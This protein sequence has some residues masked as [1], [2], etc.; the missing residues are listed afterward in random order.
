MRSLSKAVLSSV[1]L[2]GL[3]LLGPRPVCGAEADEATAR[4]VSAPAAPNAHAPSLTYRQKWALLVG[5]NAYPNL[6]LQYQLHYAVDDVQALKKVLVNDYGFPESNITVLTDTQ[7]TLSAIRQALARYA[8][9]QVDQNDQLLI[10]FSGHG[11]TVQLPDHGEMGFILPSDAVVDM[12]DTQNLSPYYATCLP[13]E[14]LSR[15]SRGIPAKH[16]LFLIDA[17]YSG[18]AI[19]DGKGLKP[20][21]PAYL[22]TVATLR[23]RQVITGG[24]KGEQTVEKS[25]WGHGAFTLKLLEGLTSGVADTNKDNIITG[26]ELAGY[27]RTVVPGIAHQTPQ[28]GYFDGDGEF[29]FMKPGVCPGPPVPSSTGED[30][31]T[32]GG[33]PAWGAWVLGIAVP[34]ALVAAVVS[35]ARKRRVRTKG[36]LPHEQ[37]NAAVKPTEQMPILPNRIRGRDNAPMALV[38]AG[39]F[40]MGSDESESD[41]EQPAHAVT[42]QAFYIDIFEVTNE[43][44]AKFL[45][46]YGKETD[47]EGNPLLDLSADSCLIELGADSRYYA[48]PGYERHPVIHV[49][50]FGAAA[51]AAHYG[52]RLPTEAEWEG[53]ARGMPTDRAG[54]PLHG[55][56][57]A[58][59]G[60]GVQLQPVG[61]LPA[62]AFGLHDM[63]GNVSEWCQDWY[64]DDRYVRAESATPGGSATGERRV[65]RGGAWLARTADELSPIRRD[66]EFSKK[67]NDSIGFRCAQD[68]TASRGAAA[69]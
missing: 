18:L 1:F 29:L 50:W 46:A 66:K 33:R 40:W 35:A 62:G 16:V 53:A 28:F 67:A 23:V 37:A 24:L 27:L 57:E 31:P 47:S 2:G 41:D 21:L 43:Q 63:S 32:P 4:R 55:F 25:D 64:A 49:T 61:Q 54:P 65:I 19:S 13:M 60:N 38:P 44:Y 5:I 68:A 3:V 17:C 7:A 12:T 58:N 30:T 15:I 22:R 59:Y 36:L 9:K 8:D 10:Y 56:S 42:L 14:E 6:P 20:S 45:T 34:V 39:R 48:K 52:K 51:Y 26:M 11:Q 69:G